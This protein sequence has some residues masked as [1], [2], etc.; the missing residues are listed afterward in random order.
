MAIAMQSSVM[1]SKLR[2]IRDV[3]WTFTIKVW[4]GRRLLRPLALIGEFCMKAQYYRWVER[5][6][7]G[8]MLAGIVGMFQP[9][10]IVIYGL[11]FPLLFFATLAFI[12][13]SHLPVREA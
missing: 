1:P 11:A 8:C 2:Q 13:V 12:V 4:R 6:V 9:F 5:T 7:I 3:Q 10:S